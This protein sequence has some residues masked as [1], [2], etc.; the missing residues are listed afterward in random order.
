MPAEWCEFDD[1][2]LHPVVEGKKQNIHLK[3]F[4]MAD[5]EAVKAWTK[6]SKARVTG[7]TPE[8]TVNVLIEGPAF[9]WRAEFS[10]GWV[11]AEPA[12]TVYE[13]GVSHSFALRKAE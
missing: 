12:E 13:A 9:P 10:H 11:S 5:K 4:G 6:G 2:I 8:G 3:R 1:E 7:V